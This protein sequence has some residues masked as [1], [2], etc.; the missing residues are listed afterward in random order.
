M[1]Q[2]LRG[3]STRQ[4]LASLEKSMMSSLVPVWVTEMTSN[5]SGDFKE[6]RMSQNCLTW[7]KL[8]AQ[9]LGSERARKSISRSEK[10]TVL[11]LVDLDSIK[12]DALVA[13]RK[14]IL[15]QN[16]VENNGI[17]EMKANVKHYSIFPEML[18]TVLPADER[19]LFERLRRPVCECRKKCMA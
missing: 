1:Q 3:P 10:K 8:S 13:R 19:P 4:A 18:R 5:D 15:C 6:L 2:N 14:L 9:S 11:P 16:S 7:M 12:S 17:G